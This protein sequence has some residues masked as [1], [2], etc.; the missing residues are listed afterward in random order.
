MIHRT[1]DT[2]FR[3]IPKHQPLLPPNELPELL[4]TTPAAFSG[5]CLF[6][7]LMFGSI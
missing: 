4:Q 7:G 2:S 6:L 5:V 1:K 3:S